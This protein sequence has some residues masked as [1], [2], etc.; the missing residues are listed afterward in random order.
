M[1]TLEYMAPEQVVSDL[2]DARTD[3]Y[4]LGVVMFRAFTGELPFRAR[5][6]RSSSP[7][8]S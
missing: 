8:S 3:V 5:S 2:P 4:G 1:G 7:G 6:S